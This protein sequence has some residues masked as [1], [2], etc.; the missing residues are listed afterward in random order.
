MPSWHYF[1]LPNQ[2]QHKSNQS[3]Q[4]IANVNEAKLLY[5]AN[6]IEIVHYVIL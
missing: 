3:L 1:N 5:V 4:I 2:I 6:N